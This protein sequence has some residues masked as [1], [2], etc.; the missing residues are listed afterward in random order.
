MT[1]T[2]KVVPG[3]VTAGHAVLFQDTEAH[4]CDVCA[5]AL[6]EEKDEADEHGLP[7][8]S[9]SGLLV[10]SRGD[11]RRY[12]EPPLCSSCATA[13]GVTA[14]QRWEIEEEEG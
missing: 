7:T 3:F 5:S 6:D 11:E 13:I 10:W 12:Q 8:N 2:P 9:G 1:D 4:R 14:H